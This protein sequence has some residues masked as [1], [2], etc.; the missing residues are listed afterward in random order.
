MV[1]LSFKAGAAVVEAMINRK[2]LIMDGQIT[3]WEGKE[4]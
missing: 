3:Y 1:Y 4:E 2:E